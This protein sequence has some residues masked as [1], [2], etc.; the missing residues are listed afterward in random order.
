MC[1]CVIKI[2]FSLLNSE[3][4]KAQAVIKLPRVIRPCGVPELALEF[5]DFKY[6]C[7]SFPPISIA[8][9]RMYIKMLSSIFLYYLHFFI[10]CFPFALVCSF[11]HLQTRS[12][13]ITVVIFTLLW[14]TNLVYPL[15]HFVVQHI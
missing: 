12:P 11:S 1:K 14:F 8:F 3:K 2:L 4:T 10:M 15:Y 9:L 6:K 7:Y 13:S 5:R